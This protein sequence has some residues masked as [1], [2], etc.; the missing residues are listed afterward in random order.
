MCHCPLI[1]IK[2]RKLAREAGKAHIPL[3]SLLAL[4]ALSNPS[5]KRCEVGLYRLGT[6]AQGN[7]VLDFRY[8]E[9]T[10]DPQGIN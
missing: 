5:T 1:I 2:R 4:N 7:H 6:A 8:M 9:M 10:A 3:P